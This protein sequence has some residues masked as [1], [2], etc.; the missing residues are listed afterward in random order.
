MVIFIFW[1]FEGYFFQGL[2]HVENEPNAYGNRE[3]KSGVHIGEFVLG[4]TLSDVNRCYY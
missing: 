2:V 3:S 1:L 4:G